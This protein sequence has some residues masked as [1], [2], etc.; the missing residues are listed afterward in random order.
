MAAHGEQH[1][2]TYFLRTINNITDNLIPLDSVINEKFIPAL[3]GRDVTEAERE[4]LS[5]PVREG[6]L[7]IRV[8]NE[9]SSQSYHASRNITAP[10]VEQIKKQADS[11]PS[12]DIVK[13]ARSTTMQRIHSIEEKNIEDIKLKQSEDMKRN[14]EQI[15]EPGASSWMGALPL[16]QYGFDL[17]KGEFHD[18]LCLRYKKIRR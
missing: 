16:S 9:I 18:A 5:M 17:N 1:R 15:S 10:L 3:C 2:Y 13:K 11:L 4:V 7:G 14:L 12:E 8:I 6:G